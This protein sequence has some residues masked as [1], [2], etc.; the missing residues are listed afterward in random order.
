MAEYVVNID[1]GVTWDPNAP[2]AAL[3]A[4]DNGTATL[5][6]SP[7]SADDDERDVLL[8]WSGAKVALMEPPNDEAITGHRLFLAG[9]NA[10]RCIGE[11]AEST[12]ISELERA[13]RVHPRRDPAPYASLRHWIVPLKEC[14]IEIIA[15][16]LQARRVNVHPSSA[17]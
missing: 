13:N 14:T 3:T 6:L 7:H 1:L 15:Q 2:D 11:V 12:L 16:S 9:L 4:F 10:V 8:V 17:P 5:R